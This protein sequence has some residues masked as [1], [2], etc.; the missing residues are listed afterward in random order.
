MQEYLDTPVHGADARSGLKDIY[1]S[2]ADNPDIGSINWRTAGFSA[3]WPTL[4][5]QSRVG[6]C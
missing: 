5:H 4:S 2:M 3:G 6:R 1:G